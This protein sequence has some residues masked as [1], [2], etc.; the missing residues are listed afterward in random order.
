MNELIEKKYR[1]EVSKL[2]KKATHLLEI[3]ARLQKTCE[4]RKEQLR[5]DHR[6]KDL[7]K[8]RD[9]KLYREIVSE[10]KEQKDGR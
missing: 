1:V 10:L 4:R 7:L 2:A 9:P 3:I 8:A 6:L 5:L